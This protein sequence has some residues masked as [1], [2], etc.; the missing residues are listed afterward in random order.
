MDA[1]RVAV[2]LHIVLAV[3]LMGMGLFW[4]VMLVALRQR[5]SPEETERWLLEARGARWPHVL[6]P[7]PARLPLQWVS[8]LLLVALVLTGGFMTARHGMPSGP[9]W[10]L[11]LLLVGAIVGVQILSRR[12]PR[13]GA[14]RAG[15]WL[16][17]A[18]IV[19]SAIALRT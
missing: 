15:F 4:L 8:W 13:A 12:R 1:Y 18:V 6:V 11:K 19:V 14:I 5:F 16:T 3:V 7:R 10:G 17:L 9:L 2:F